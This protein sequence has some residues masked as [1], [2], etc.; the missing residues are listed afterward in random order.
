MYGIIHFAVADADYEIGPEIRG[1]S[2]S[3][4]DVERHAA[5]ITLTANGEKKDCFMYAI[6]TEPFEEGDMFMGSL[7][8][9][10]VPVDD[11][12]TCYQRKADID[13][14]ELYSMVGRNTGYMIDSEAVGYSPNNPARN[15]KRI[16]CRVFITQPD[17]HRKIRFAKQNRRKQ[18]TFPPTH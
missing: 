6:V 1:M 14:E 7:D 4:P 5:Y 13:G 2:Y 15:W 8:V 3:N 18:R 9:V 17:T 12:N 16:P 10:F 11:T